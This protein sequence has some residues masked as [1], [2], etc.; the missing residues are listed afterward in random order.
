MSPVGTIASPPNPCQSRP[1]GAFSFFWTCFTCSKW[2]DMM[3]FFKRMSHNARRVH[4]HVSAMFLILT[5]LHHHVWGGFCDLCKTSLDCDIKKLNSRELCERMQVGEC[6]IKFLS[7]Y[8]THNHLF[9]LSHLS[10]GNTLLETFRGKAT[11]RK[12]KSC[13][14]SG[15][16]QTTLCCAYYTQS[17]NHTSNW[18]LAFLFQRLVFLDTCDF[19]Q[20]FSNLPSTGSC[21]CKWHV[22]DSYTA[23]YRKFEKPWMPQ[24]PCQTASF[25]K[26]FAKAF[27][28]FDLNHCIGRLTKSAFNMLRWNY[29]CTRI[30]SYCFHK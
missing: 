5:S 4:L 17:K 28:T 15:K 30:I 2:W 11:T 25:A 29:D 22:H 20:G 16:Y 12:S 18:S 24:S 10:L 23:R 7:T 26:A 1:A 27:T 19:A 21:W 8:L 6:M 3:S 9:G 13:L 14:L